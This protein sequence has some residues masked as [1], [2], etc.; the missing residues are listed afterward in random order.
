MYMYSNTCMYMY[1]YMYMSM[2]VGSLS[3]GT[4]LSQQAL[5]LT[6]MYP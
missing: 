1:M 6:L 5:N 3:Q 2:P 4:P